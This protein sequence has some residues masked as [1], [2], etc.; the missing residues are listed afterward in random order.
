MDQAN[1]LRVLINKQQPT[2]N[3][4]VTK[5]EAPEI[6]V[7]P[8]LSSR[9]ITIASGK[10]GVGKTNFTI[11]L[12]ICLS[13]MKHRVVIIDADFGL[14]NIEIILGV[15][16]RYSFADVVNGQ[17]N[18]LDALTDCETGIKFISGGSGFKDLAYVTEEQMA[19]V[20]RNFTV[21][22]AISDV[23][24]IDTGAGISNSVMNFITAS[25]EAIIVTTPEPTAITDAYALIKTAKETVKKQNKTMPNFKLI[26]NKVDYEDEGFEVFQKLNR[27]TERFLDIKLKYA[28]AIPYDNNL[29]KAVKKQ[30]P[31]TTLFPGTIFSKAIGKISGQ[32]VDDRQ[33]KKEP[34]GIISF[35]KRLT[36]IFGN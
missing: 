5:E 4:V 19:N 30:Q 10:G 21:L 26:I 27:V 11:N 32:L 20:I 17:M 35:M 24:L 36:G 16:P 31:V 1:N 23:I 25:D 18:I 3:I 14:S 33:T 7:N 9:V 15:I 6:G 2:D 28:G 29:V 34:L 12:A 22:D 8:A 13:R